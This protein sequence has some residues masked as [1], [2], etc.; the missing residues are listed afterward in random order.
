MLQEAAN[1]FTNRTDFAR[2]NP[3]AYSTAARRGVLNDIC[4][5][6]I[7]KQAARYSDETIIKTAAQF[8]HSSQFRKAQPSMYQAAHGRGL[9]PQIT[10]NMT[11]DTGSNYPAYFAKKWAGFTLISMNDDRAIVQCQKCGNQWSSLPHKVKCNFCARNSLTPAMHDELLTIV[12]NDTIKRLSPYVKKTTKVT[13]LCAQAHTWDAIPANVLNGSGCPTCS[14]TGP[15]KAEREI[16]SWVEN[17]GIKC[18]ANSKAIIGPLELDIYIPSRN[19]AIEY[20]GAYW[21][22]FHDKQYHLIK[23]QRC[24]ELGIRLIHI[25]EHERDNLIM[26]SIIANA[27]GVSDV[28]IG[29]RQC[30]VSAVPWSAAKAF[31][32]ANHIQGAGAASSLNLALTYGGAIVSIMTFGKPRFEKAHDWELMR[33]AIKRNTRVNGGALKLWKQ[34]PAGS[35]MSYSDRRLFDG[36]LYGRLG[37]TKTHS[38]DPGYFYTNSRG[39]T[40]LRYNTQRSKLAALLGDKFDATMS[41][42]D[43]MTRAGWRKIWDC[44]TVTWSFND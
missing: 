4:G 7:A 2:G 5:H 20:N 3:A 37:F 24:E 25:W 13:Y 43:N 11:R 10:A 1:K 28:T 31:L 33:Y 40:L 18:V 15:S 38:S 35:I 36:Q 44:G 30:V 19:I 39:E 17:L 23:T 6:M 12:H 29:A 9:L 32:D 21:H 8:E 27:V 26:R 22:S 41:E 34:R 16:L 42:H 14:T